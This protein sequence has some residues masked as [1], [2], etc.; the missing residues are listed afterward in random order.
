MRENLKWQNVFIFHLSHY[1]I[2]CCSFLLKP[3]MEEKIY[4]LMYSS[5]VS[6]FYILLYFSLSLFFVSLFYILLYFSLSLFFFF[7]SLSL[8]WFP[9]FELTSGRTL[10]QQSFSLLM[11]EVACQKHQYTKKRVIHY[12]TTFP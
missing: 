7:F 10:F 8:K 1:F 12:I 9:S 4:V 6:L 2:Y 5:S 11:L 3:T